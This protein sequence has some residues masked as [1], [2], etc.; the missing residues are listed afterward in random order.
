MI[1]CHGRPSNPYHY[2]LSPPHI[3]IYM[4]ILSSLSL[5]SL[6]PISL[7]G[8][9]AQSREVRFLMKVRGL[10]E[11]G[12]AGRPNPKPSPPVRASSTAGRGW[13]SAGPLWKK[14]ESVLAASPAPRTPSFPTVRCTIPSPASLPGSLSQLCP[15]HTCQVSLAHSDHSVWF[16]SI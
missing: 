10:S 1:F 2:L 4:H 15:R 3:H 7:K 14:L 11:C 6:P 5:S 16:F 13:A 9:L 8:P 12:R